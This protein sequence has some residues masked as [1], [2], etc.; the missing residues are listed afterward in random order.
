MPFGTAL[1]LVRDE[2]RPAAGDVL[3]A[4]R[5]LRP[6]RGD[7]QAGAERRGTTPEVDALIRSGG[8][9]R[10]FVRVT[11]VVRGPPGHRSCPATG[12]PARG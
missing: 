5:D 7:E 10:P 11:V 6:F 3:R 4:T 12:S 8:P 1:S 2:D 9:Y